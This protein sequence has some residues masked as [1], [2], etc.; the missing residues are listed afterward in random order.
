M[1]LLLHRAIVVDELVLRRRRLV[2]L[3]LGDVVLYGRAHHRRRRV[4]DA[5]V[6]VVRVLW[7]L[8]RR[9]GHGRRGGTADAFPVVLPGGSGGRMVVRAGSSVEMMGG[10]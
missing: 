4:G 2:V 8:H 1:L 7:V 9:K 6:V 3:V 10:R 5:I